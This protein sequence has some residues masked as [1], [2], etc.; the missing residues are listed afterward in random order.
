MIHI[1][2]LRNGFSL[3]FCFANRKR[4]Y[5]PARFSAPLVSAVKRHCT[6]ATESALRCWR[7]LLKSLVAR[8]RLMKLTLLARSTAGVQ[9]AKYR[10]LS[11]FANATET[12]G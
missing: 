12:C 1:C 5:P 7:P 4:E 11:A 9:R 10:L 3:R 2:R 6:C 8:L